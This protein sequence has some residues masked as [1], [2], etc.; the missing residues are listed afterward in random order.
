MSDIRMT[1]RYCVNVFLVSLAVLLS[2]MTSRSVKTASKLVRI[3]NQ[4]NVANDKKKKNKQKQQKKTKQNTYR[5]SAG[6]YSTS[7]SCYDPSGVKHFNIRSVANEKPSQ[8]E[9]YC[10]QHGGKLPTKPVHRRT[11]DR[12]SKN[13]TNR[14]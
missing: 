14:N 3:P 1:L 2:E 12:T 5:T 6:D 10:A 11:T 4:T 13:S 9:W 7:N 8:N